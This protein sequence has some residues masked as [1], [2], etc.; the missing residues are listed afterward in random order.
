MINHDPITNHDYSMVFD[1]FPLNIPKC[2]WCQA[3][4]VNE[5]VISAGR[6]LVLDLSCNIAVG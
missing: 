2:H 3:C 1:I 6:E 5:A 4:G